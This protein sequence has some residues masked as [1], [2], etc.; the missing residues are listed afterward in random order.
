M[1]QYE[2]VF[3]YSPGAESVA[4]SKEAVVSQFKEHKF[5]VIDEN[6]MGERDLAYEIKKSE[7]GHYVRYLL[8]GDSGNAKPVEEALRL[9][10]GILKFV[11][12][13]HE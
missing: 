11:F 6:D 3:I 12:F 8:E 2:A 4:S 10:S 13:R 9:K 7:R 5:K 1:K